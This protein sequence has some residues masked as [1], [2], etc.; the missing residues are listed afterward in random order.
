[1]KIAML[2]DKPIPNERVTGIGVVAYQLSKALALTGM[3]ITLIGRGMKSFTSTE[4]LISIQTI[5]DYT[6]Q[7]PMKFL[8][9]YLSNRW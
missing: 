7:L 2:M 4:N 6:T 3:D 1:M 8:R 5:P 9:T